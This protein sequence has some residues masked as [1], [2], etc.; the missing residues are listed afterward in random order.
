M[1]QQSKYRKDNIF[2]DLDPAMT[3]E[4]VRI[5][6][7]LRKLVDNFNK[8]YSQL[9]NTDELHVTLGIDQE[10]GYLGLGITY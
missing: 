10:T 7:N 6:N 4:K 3:T 2:N 8:A 9:R 1:I 5:A